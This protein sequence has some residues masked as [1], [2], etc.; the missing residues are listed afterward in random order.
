MN[1][2]K[3]I[4]DCGAH[5]GQDSSYYLTSGYK[6]LAIDASPSLSERMKTVFASAI[7]RKD[8]SIINVAIS[9][10]AG[11]ISFFESTESVWNSAKLEIANRHNCL[12]TKI[13]VDS[14]RLSDIV[15]TNGEVPYY[16]K[17]DLEGNDY[18]AIMSLKDVDQ[19]LMPQY[20]SCETECIGEH[21]VISEDEALKTLEALKE[22]GYT[23]FKLVDQAS[24]C[25]VNMQNFGSLARPAHLSNFVFGS[26]GPF[27]EDIIAEW[28]DYEEAKKLLTTFRKWF[29][30]FPRLNYQFWC[31]WHATK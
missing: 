23:K 18:D 19:S 16:I 15:I 13:T 11:E 14:L 21:E 2:K 24:M 10:E 27:G 30:S 6:V 12:Q 3:L 29:F 22:V 26:T 9:K 8:F 5:M 20:I 1:E 7:E 28:I 17:I 4:I 25:P 31:D